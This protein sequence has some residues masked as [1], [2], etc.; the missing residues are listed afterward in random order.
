[1]MRSIFFNPENRQKYMGLFQPVKELIQ[2]QESLGNQVLLPKRNDRVFAVKVKDSNLIQYYSVKLRQVIRQF[3]IL[4]DDI[5]F[6]DRNHEEQDPIFA[7]LQ[8]KEESQINLTLLQRQSNEVALKQRQRKK[9]IENFKTGLFL[10]G[11]KYSERI[12]SYDNYI[13]E[14]HLEVVKNKIA[15][16]MKDEMKRMQE[17]IQTQMVADTKRQNEVKIIEI[18]PQGRILACIIGNDLFIRVVNLQVQSASD[19]IN[20]RSGHQIMNSFMPIY[21]DLDYYKGNKEVERLEKQA[22]DGE[23]TKNELKVIALQSESKLRKSMLIFH[24][25]LSNNIQC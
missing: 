20:K 15:G 4:K 13:E 24:E 5:Y 12:P 11:Y 19:M 23:T 7:S 2:F 9:E 1:M 3:S 22:E 6:D 14:R 17:E 8:P 21:L 25:L 16:K 10:Q 18:S